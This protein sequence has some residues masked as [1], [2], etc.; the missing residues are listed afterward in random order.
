MIATQSD[1][2]KSVWFR[3]LVIAAVAVVLGIVLAL[4]L[5]LAQR[6]AALKTAPEDN[7]Q[8]FLARLEVDFLKLQNSVDL[9][10]LGVADLEDLRLRYDIFF[11]RITLMHEGRATRW[12]LAFPEDKANLTKISDF[13]EKSVTI[14]DAPDRVL[15]ARVPQLK[16]GLDQIEQAVARFALSA[17]SKNAE[18]SDGQRVEIIRLLQSIAG[19]LFLLFVA[20]LAAILVLIRQKGRLNAKTVEVETGNAR[21]A[22]TLGASLDAI[23]V[24]RHDGTIIDFN[25]SAEEVFQ[26]ERIDALGR[27]YFETLVPKH[28]RDTY[29]SRF[30]SADAEVEAE[31]Q[32]ELAGT[33]NA[34][35]GRFQVYALRADGAEIPVEVSVASAQGDDGPIHIAYLRDITQD[36]EREDQLLIAR[37]EALAAYKEKSKFLAVMSH[38]M[39]TPLNGIVSALDLMHDT[40]L[41]KEQSSFLKAAETSSEILI[42]H[43]NDVL[44][45]ERIESG[46]GNDRAEPVDIDAVLS[47]TLEAVRAVADR[48][49]TR[50]HLDRV[51][52]DPGILRIDKRGLQ[53]VL[54][55]L[56]S[57]AIKFTPKGDVTLSATV[58]VQGDNLAQLKFQVSD[59]GQGIEE[60][61]QLRIFEDFVTVDSTYERRSQGTGLGLG[62]ARRLVETLGGN[63]TCKS[64][65]QE[66]SVFS[67][68]VMVPTGAENPSSPKRRTTGEHPAKLVSR[69]ILLVE[70]NLLNR[71]LLARILTNLGQNVDEA[72]DGFEGVQKA[73]IKH[74]DLI[75][76]DISMPNLNGVRAT[77]MIRGSRGLSRNTPI[78]AVTAHALPDDKKRFERVGM[79]GTMTKP[80]RKADVERFLATFKDPAAPR[81][82]P[83]VRDETPA[84]PNLAPLIDQDHFGELKEIFDGAFAQKVQAFTTTFSRDLELLAE[85]SDLTKI[86]EKVHQMAGAAATFGAKRLHGNLSRIEAACKAGQ[87]EKAQGLND[88]L[89]TIWHDT[90]AAY[91]DI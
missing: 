30:Q 31:L 72:A 10:M 29:R 48:Q 54:L 88:A 73:S 16:V 85:T 49:E 74:Y 6:I 24:V 57:N 39:R 56:L 18:R 76:M 52:D 53:Q 77:E 22:S 3:A 17:I 69:N 87:L 91:Q 66:G 79:A 14:I 59:T 68:T 45:I 9:Y 33:Q 7:T 46:T 20:L 89:K 55:N 70:D 35:S 19:A 47:Q 61:D 90:K 84:D 1:P 32:A 27:N 86:Q 28:L 38:E 41:T 15:A 64:T 34:R 80:V 50:L 81:S 51:G 5:I 2:I 83:T 42:G 82:D 71:Q 62:I 44:D 60:R 58:K 4:S 78:Y 37:D 23:V 63:L 65:P 43:V 26:F 11:S 67:F 8:W 13:L 40:P 36:L 21:L 25:G 12:L 75:F